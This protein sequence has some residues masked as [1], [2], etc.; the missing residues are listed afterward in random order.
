MQTSVA[1]GSEQCFRAAET[2]QEAAA[3]NRD[4]L[5][6]AT[7]LMSLLG[8]PAARAQQTCIPIH[9]AQ[10]QSSATVRGIARNDEPASC[11]T[12]TARRGQTATLNIVKQSPKDDTAFTIPGVVDNQDRYTFK[13][14]DKTYKITVYLTFARQ[15]PRPF[16]MQVT[17]SGT[18]ASASQH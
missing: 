18:A 2:G 1:C 9:F 4:S 3:M 14:E 17:V 5:I 11:Y 8:S 12:L 10:G 15:P 16:S 7:L 13:T 6:A